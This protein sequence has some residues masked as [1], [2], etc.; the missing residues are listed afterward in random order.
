[1][2]TKVTIMDQV[3]NNLFVGIDVHK[4]QW[5]V[6][7][8]TLE[9]EHRKFTQEPK[10]SLLHDYLQK[11]FPSYQI[12]CAYEAGAFGFWISGELKKYG[13]NCLILN[14]ADIPGSDKELKHKTDRSDC[15]KIARELSKGGLRGIYEPNTDQLSLR[16]LFRQRNQFVKQIRAVKCQIKSLLCFNG[17][18]IVKEYERNNWSKNFKGWLKDLPLPNSNDRSALNFMLRKLDFLSTEFRILEKQLHSQLASTE[19]YKFYLSVPGIGPVIATAIA[20]ELGDLSRFKNIDNLCSYVGLVP[21]IYQSGDSLR[22]NGM[23]GRC[24]HLLRSYFIEA[25]WSAV[26]KDPELTLYYKKQIGK[27]VAGKVIVK[28]ARKLLVRTYY[29]LKYKR[30]YIKNIN[31]H[32]TISDRNVVPAAHKIQ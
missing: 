27:K 29:C 22:V 25:A 21:N 5:S 24:N 6:C 7:I 4:K 2:E 8:R 26:G 13:Y 28:I 9:L 20:C 32:Q 23:T 12:T 18:V 16:N 31:Q 14:P 1:M 17:I 19:N 15:R 3:Q 30:E 11:N 10:P